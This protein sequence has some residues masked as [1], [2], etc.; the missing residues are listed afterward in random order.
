MAPSTTLF[1]LA[2]VM[3][4]SAY[5]SNLKKIKW[6]KGKLENLTMFWLPLQIDQCDDSTLSRKLGSIKQGPHEFID[7][8]VIRIIPTVIIWHAILLYKQKERT[9]K[10]NKLS[11]N[12]I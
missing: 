8:P 9:V 12:I 6:V 3:S 1:Q 10:I 4:I 5:V 2:G 7:L 11:K